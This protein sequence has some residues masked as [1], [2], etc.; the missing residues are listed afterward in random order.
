MYWRS[1]IHT[2]LLSLELQQ[3]AL[4]KPSIQ[5]RSPT[6]PNSNHRSIPHSARIAHADTHLDMTVA[7]LQVSVCKGGL[8]KGHWQAKCSSSK[9]SQST[10]LVDNQ[11]KGTHGWHG[12]KGKNSDLVGVHTEEPRC[13]EFS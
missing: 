13:D 8:K 1:A 11:S 3:C 5:Y 6:D 2:M 12:R 7:L 4:A 9:N 10:A